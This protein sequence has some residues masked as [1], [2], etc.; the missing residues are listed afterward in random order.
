MSVIVVGG[1]KGGV[2]KSTLAI[3][4]AAYLASGK[5][6]VIVVDTDTQR[7]AVRWDEL[8]SQYE[9]AKSFTVVEKTVDPAPTIV[10]LSAKYDVVVVDVGA[11]DYARLSD[12]SR[13]ADLWIAPTRVGQ[14]DLESTLDLAESFNQVHSKHKAKHIPLCMLVNCVPGAWNSTE[15]DDAVKALAEAVPTGTV[16][17]HTIRERRVW[18]DAHRLG[19]TIFEMPAKQA[20]KAQDEFD[21]A[22][23]EALAVMKKGKS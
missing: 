15:G 10:Q 4:I 16:L 1:E 3:T 7:T 2:G 22:I 12:L 8:R 17:K 19:A 11:R 23:K 5:L 9:R 13:I 18:R 21:A 6:S 20:E 14:G